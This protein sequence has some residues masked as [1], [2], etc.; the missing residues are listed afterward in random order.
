MTLRYEGRVEEEER[1]QRKV[2]E[3]WGQWPPY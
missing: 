2:N 1:V 3:R